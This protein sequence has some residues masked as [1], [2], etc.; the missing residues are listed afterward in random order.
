[1][2]PTR[3]VA[4]HWTRTIALALPAIAMLAPIGRAQ[5]VATRGPATSVQPASSVQRPSGVTA[6]PTGL[7]AIFQSL[8]GEH[9]LMPGLRWADFGVKRLEG[10]H[11]YSCTFVKRERI[12]GE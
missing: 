1:M 7:R 5:E 8:A 12:D 2:P 6:A 9:P 10:V 4:R 11:D 3:H